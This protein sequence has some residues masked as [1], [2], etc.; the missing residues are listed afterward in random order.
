MR[1]A[2]PLVAIAVISCLFAVGTGTGA[3]APKAKDERP[4]P[5]TEEQLETTTNN[6]KQI[7]LAWHNY[8]AANGDLPSD[9]VDAKGKPILSWRVLILPYIEDQ[10]GLYKGFKL[11]EPWDSADNKKLIDAMPKIFAPVRG[12]ADPGFTF[13]QSFSGKRGLLKP[14]EKIG[15]ANITDGTSTT[16]MVAEA[17]KPVIWTK[18]GDLVFD[19]KDVP[20]LGG[21]FDGKFH[22][23]F[24][25]GSVE[26]FRKGINDEALRRLIDPADGDVV[27][28]SDGIDK[29]EEK[30]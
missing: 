14:G 28:R 24:C 4:G 22:A 2:V 13:Y 11:D 27:D 26:R 15:F 20:A 5:I 25:D 29:D 16:L 1:W 7:A 17:A 19:G 8:E 9:V 30:K 21:M 23:A 3:P 10:E 12:K 6:L 18:P